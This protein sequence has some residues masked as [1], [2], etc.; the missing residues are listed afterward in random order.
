MSRAFQSPTLED[1]DR[2]FKEYV[3]RLQHNSVTAGADEGPFACPC[4]GYLTLDE[5]GEFE[6]CNV[7]FWED[8][9]Q[10]EHDAEIV[11]SGPNSAEL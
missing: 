9:D 10:D 1:R 8:D 3:G 2:W 11:Q 4:C 5:R 7:C 6:I